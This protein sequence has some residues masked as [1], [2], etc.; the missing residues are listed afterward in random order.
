MDGVILVVVVRVLAAVGTEEEKPLVIFVEVNAVVVVK[1]VRRRE[2][3]EVAGMKPC[4][5]EAW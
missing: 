1:A 3:F 5:R 4:R 2:R